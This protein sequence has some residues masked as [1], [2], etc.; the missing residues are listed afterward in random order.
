MSPSG[1]AVPAGAEAAGQLP[2]LCGRFRIEGRALRCDRHG[3]GHINET[4]LVT[5]D[6]DRAYILQKINQRVFRDIPALMANIASVT[7][8][9]AEQDGDPRHVLTLVR[10]LGGEDFLHE[11][12]GGWWRMYVYVDGS[13]CLD[14]AETKRDFCQSAAAFGR[15]QRG[16]AAFPAESLSETIPGF[17]DTPLRFAAL[18]D[19]VEKDPLHRAAEAAPEIAFARAR[20]RGAGR[21]TALQKE[22][23]LPLRVTHNDAKLNNVLLD[24]GT[25]EPLCVI[26]LD[27]VMPGLA[28]NDFGDSIRFGASTAAED[29]RDLRKVS[30]SLEL[31]EA[32]AASFLDACGEGL[33]REEIGTLPLAARLMTLECGVRFLTDHLLGDS[34][35]H[36]ARPNHNLERCRTQFALVADMERRY[37]DLCRIIGR[38]A[39]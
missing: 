30:L 7:R 35:F 10:T 38:E 24:A 1:K 29:E 27:T 6:A 2:S 4:W 39:P 33:T 36:I 9:L 15:F 17:H 16:L 23:G 28:G 11:G 5:T 14:K 19:A 31:F 37:R 3:N 32:Y 21:M 12:E 34:Y 22:G 25:R 26:D 20:R 18:E 8:F 13:I